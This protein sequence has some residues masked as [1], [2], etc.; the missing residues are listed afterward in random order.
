M[1]QKAGRRATED[2]PKSAARFI[3]AGARAILARGERISQH[4]AE[5]RALIEWADHLGKRLP[6]NYIEQFSF[7]G[8]G[9]EHRVYKD[10][11]NL[12][13][14]AIKATHPNKF[15][16]STRAEFEWAT[17][18][19]YLKRLA[20]QN[21]IFGD[22]IRMIGVAY[23]DAQMEVVTSQPWIDV[24]EIRPN[25]TF[26]EIEQY[27]ARFGF[28][29]TSFDRDTPLYFSRAHG[30]VAADAHDRNVLRDFNGN[31]IAIDLVIGPPG[32]HIRQKIDEFLNGPKLPF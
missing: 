27:M 24:H 8:D 3:R 7:V 1:A 19:E 20:W 14:F 12:R 15:G 23:E 29:S 28:I 5:Y 10:D 22:D 17:P 6:F 13:Q 9:A 21:H 2:S 4:R 25:P 11:G 31:L 26:E 16:Y 32:P 30:L 18:V